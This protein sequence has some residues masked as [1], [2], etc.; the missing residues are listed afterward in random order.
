MY[1][2]KLAEKFGGLEKSAYLCI[3]FRNEGIKDSDLWKIYIDREVV[4][5]ASACICYVYEY[6][7]KRYEPFNSCEEVA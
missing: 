4:Q 1:T 7:G 3:R 6:L 5:E 2:K